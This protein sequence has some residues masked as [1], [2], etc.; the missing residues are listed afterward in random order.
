MMWVLAV[1]CGAALQAPAAPA[2]RATRGGLEVSLQVEAPPERPPVRGQRG[3]KRSRAKAAV[4]GVIRQLRG[5]TAPPIPVGKPAALSREPAAPHGESMGREQARHSWGRGMPKKIEDDCAAVANPSELADLLALKRAV[6][7][8]VPSRD[9]DVGSHQVEAEAWR[10]D[11]H[12]DVRLL[13]FLRKHGPDAACEYSS[14]LAWRATRSADEELDVTPRCSQV[15][16]R[17]RSGAAM[18]V[19]G[20]RGDR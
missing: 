13:R 4:V 6:W 2:G 17:T 19:V 16:P 14:M 12:G 9:Q 7:P 10:A 8:R 18:R 5:E 1:V 20:R 15:I 11:V 3:Y